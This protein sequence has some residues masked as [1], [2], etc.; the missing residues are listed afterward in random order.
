M[1]ALVVGA[2][3]FAGRWLLRHLVESGDEV[4]A[5]V[6]PGYGDEALPANL[7]P[8][9]LDVRDPDGVH[10]VVTSSQPDVIYYLA[11]VSRAGARDDLDLAIGISVHGALNTLAAAADLDGPIR[12]VHIGSSHVYATPANEEPIDERAP[13]QPTSVYGAAK[14]AA[15]SALQYL[16][17]AAGV[18]VIAVRAFNHTGP[19]QQPGFVVPSLARQVIEIERGAKEPIIRAGDLDARRDFT[20]VRD[21]VRAYRLAA[22]HGVPG[23]AYNVASGRAIRVHEILDELLG[24]RSVRAEVEQDLTLSR[25]GEPTT[26]MVGDAGK[27]TA[28]TGWRPEITIQ[29]SLVGVLDSVVEHIP[30]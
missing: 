3:G 7:D 23:E 17:A 19:G 4:A 27:L 18:E 22:V 24:L 2:D 20:D 15:E 14:A 26:A 6:G 5:A 8:L 1:R 9:R 28:L 11:G 29:Q 12:L 25:A 16:G 30:G 21:V 13:I 10:R